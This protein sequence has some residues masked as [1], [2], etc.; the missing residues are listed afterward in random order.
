MALSVKNQMPLSSLPLFL[1]CRCCF[2]GL[3]I[4]VGMTMYI[5]AITEEASNRSKPSPPDE[6]VSFRYD[7]GPSLTLMVSA[8]FVSE[9]TGVLAM[10]LHFVLRRQQQPPSKSYQDPCADQ[11]AAPSLLL[12]H[13]EESPAAPVDAMLEEICKSSSGNGAWE[14]AEARLTVVC[15]SNGN[16]VD[17]W[18]VRTTQQTR[19]ASTL[20]DKPPLNYTLSRKFGEMAS[21]TPR[22]NLTDVDLQRH[23]VTSV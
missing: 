11:V 19:R 5:G 14:K 20:S 21:I 17:S 10:Q 7:Y 18:I 2:I 23:R 8:F 3:F 6:T 9:M 22:R 15:H 1:F 16:L 4:F 12:P 13:T